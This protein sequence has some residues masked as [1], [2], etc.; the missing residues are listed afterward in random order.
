[1]ISPSTTRT[2]SLV[3]VGLGPRGIISIERLGALLPGSGVECCELHLVEEHEPGAGKVWATDQHRELCMN[4]LAGAVTLFTDDSYTGPGPILPGPTQYEWCVAVREHLAGGDWTLDAP[5]R[6]AVRTGGYEAELAQTRPESH[7]SRAL[8][9]EYLVWCF[10]RAMSRLP[11]SV[12]I[13]VRW[14]VDVLSSIGKLGA[15]PQRQSGAS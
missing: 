13:R 3:V 2:P 4:T 8:Y 6:D 15:R 10:E 7:P 12:S 9:G 14:S 1:M 5:L 11:S